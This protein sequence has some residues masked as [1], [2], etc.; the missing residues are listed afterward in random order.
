MSPITFHPCEYCTTQMHDLNELHLT[1]EG[2]KHL[3]WMHTIEK[4]I[5]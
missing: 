4:L 5:V 1:Q 3:N 2:A